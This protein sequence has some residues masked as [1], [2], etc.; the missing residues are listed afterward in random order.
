MISFAFGALCIVAAAHA[1]E[2][3]SE[4]APTWLQRAFGRDYILEGTQKSN[5]LDV[6]YLQTP[7]YFSDIRFPLD[8]PNMSTARSFADLSDQQLRA[9]SGQN[10]STGLT[11]MEGIIAHWHHDMDFQPSDGTPDQ[12]RLERVPPEQMFEHGLDG[13]YTEAWRSSVNGKG[14][15]LVVRVE[16]AG[17]LVRSLV[18]VDNLFVYARNRAKDLPMAKGF[19]ALIKTTNPSRDQLIEY[20]DCE[21]SIGHVHGDGAPWAIEKSTLPWREGK[22]LDFLKSVP[23]DILKTGRTSRTVGADQWTVPV[24]TMSPDEI[25][26]LFG[27]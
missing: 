16:H 12:G 18:V 19:D 3:V 23:I 20:L 13:S 25:K 2:P 8:R 9:L 21:F 10:G 7:E 24:N 26:G 15:F 17:R 4:Q 27:G 11:R 6:H 22:P 1:Q 14:H 5:T